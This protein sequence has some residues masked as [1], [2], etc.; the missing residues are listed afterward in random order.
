[1]QQEER[2]RERESGPFPRGS[3]NGSRAALIYEAA[4]FAPLTG[5]ISSA[6]LI[7]DRAYLAARIAC[8]KCNTPWPFSGA[9][10]WI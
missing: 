1:M 9:D 3:K 7:N 2:K 4:E 8:E 5:V 10:K 6:G